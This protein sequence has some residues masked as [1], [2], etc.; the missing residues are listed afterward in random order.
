M[1]TL[2]VLGASVAKRTLGST[3]EGA[4]TC[5]TIAPP[6]APHFARPVSGYRAA[7]GL[8]L[9][10]GRDVNRS[11]TANQVASST[12]RHSGISVTMTSVGS[13]FTRTSPP[14]LAR[15]TTE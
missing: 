1:R 4:H 7:L 8:R 13:T 12:I 5:R 3:A 10:G 9:S 2:V 6:H 11:L 14:C 15:A